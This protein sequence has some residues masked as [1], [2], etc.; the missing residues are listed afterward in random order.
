MGAL[1]GL[2][3]PLRMDGRV[4][5]KALRRLRAVGWQLWLTRR[6]GVAGRGLLAGS[7]PRTMPKLCPLCPNYAHSTSKC[8][9]KTKQFTTG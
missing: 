2:R 4:V 3:P 7:L 9:H 6:H 5:Q 8:L 1:D